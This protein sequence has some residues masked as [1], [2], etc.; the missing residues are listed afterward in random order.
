MN[1]SEIANY[2]IRN[3][4]LMTVATANAEGKPWVSPLSYTVDDN[5]NLY[6]VSHKDALHSENI[7]N[8]PEIAI[9]IVG[10]NPQDKRDGVYLDATAS[11][12][13]NT[14]EVP[15]IIAL[16]N[17]RE[18]DSKYTI[19]SVEDVTGNSAW[20]IYKAT[21]HSA[22]KRADGVSGGQA[23]TT[24]EAVNIGL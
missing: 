9:V 8:R 5:Q 20:R 15:A 23:I 22:W 4:N 1:S 19:E 2:I 6:W 16:I 13:T 12:L 18:K 14:T 24:K 7:R 11:E 10:I 21:P 3:N 17:N